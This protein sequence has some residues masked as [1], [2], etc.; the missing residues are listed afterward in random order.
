MPTQSLP[1]GMA[2]TVLQNV[3][4][5]LPSKQ[6]RIAATRLMQVSIDGVTFANV[7][8]SDTTG[9]DITGVFTRCVAGD[10]IVVCKA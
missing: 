8:G 3:I 2:V 7:V 10:A 4:Y 6:V 5:A 1:V 9:A